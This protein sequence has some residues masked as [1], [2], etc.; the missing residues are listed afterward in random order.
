MIANSVIWSSNFAV[1][2]TDDAGSESTGLSDE[3]SLHRS[4]PAAMVN[5]KL[6]P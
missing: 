1:L 6:H 3:T 4:Q 2:S 5:L